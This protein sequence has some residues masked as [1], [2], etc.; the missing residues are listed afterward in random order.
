MKNKFATEKKILFNFLWIYVFV[1]MCQM[2]HKSDNVFNTVV[3]KISCWISITNI[4]F[5]IFNT[6]KNIKLNLEIIKINVL[7]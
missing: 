1:S 3:L 4:Y 2:Q 5:T 6:G 7:N